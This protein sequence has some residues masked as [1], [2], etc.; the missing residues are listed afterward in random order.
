MSS[1]TV[2]LSAA[3]TDKLL[4]ELVAAYFQASGF[5]VERNLVQREV[6]EQNGEHRGTEEILELDILATDYNVSP[7]NQLLTEVKSGGWGF[8]DIFKLRG[9]MHYLHH[10][11]AV[12]VATKPKDHLSYYRDK[13]LSLGVRLIDISDRQNTATALSEVTKN[14]EPLRLDVSTLRFSYWI[15]RVLYDD[16]IHKKKSNRAD[17]RYIAMSDYLHAINSGAFFKQTISERMDLLCSAYKQFPNLSARAA[18]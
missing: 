12:F 14:P 15:D 13:A 6:V 5:Y 7:P 17:K 1:T 10:E 4:E 9:W 8:P 2:S 11:N 3:P 16:L 18:S